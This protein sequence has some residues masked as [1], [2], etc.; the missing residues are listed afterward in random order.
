M[1]TDRSAILSLVATGRITPREAERLLAVSRD[2]DETVLRLAVCLAFVCMVLPSVGN[3][4]TAI[5]QAMALLLPTIARA[6]LLMNGA[7]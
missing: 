6:L 4:M 2:G 5:G 7:A 1:Q 3:A